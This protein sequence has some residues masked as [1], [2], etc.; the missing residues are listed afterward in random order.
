MSLNTI[1]GVVNQIQRQ[2]G[3]VSA[4]Q[5]QFAPTGT[6]DTENKTQFSDVLF[7]SL[8]NISQ[9]QNQAK[10]GSEDYLAGVPG[11]GL[12][13]VMV[14]MQKSSVALNLGVQVRNKMVS[15]Y[16]DIMNMGV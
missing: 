11:V 14:S 15:A 9:L 8:N 13:D 4:M 5:N 6:N 3:Q 2:A 10:Q 16:Q 7:N 1:N 12:N